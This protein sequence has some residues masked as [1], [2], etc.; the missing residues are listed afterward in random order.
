MKEHFIEGDPCIGSA[1]IVYLI[2]ACHHSTERNALK[3]FW[4]CSCGFLLLLRTGWIGRV[5]SADTKS[6]GV[7]LRQTH[8]LRQEPW[9]THDGRN[10][11]RTL[12]TRGSLAQL[13]L[14]C[15]LVS[16]LRWWR[17]WKSTSDVPAGLGHSCW[18]MPT[19]LAVTARS[20]HPCCYADSTVLD[21][22]C[23]H[24]LFAS[25]S[26]LVNWTVGFMIMQTGFAPKDNF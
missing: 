2:S 11:T 4:R 9:K 26:N 14:L 5:M 24:V 22:W 17:A 20:C 13:A 6:R 23:T 15:F 16:C 21:C 12:W 25:G 19:H 10:I 8:M 18:L 1:Y 7:L 3:I